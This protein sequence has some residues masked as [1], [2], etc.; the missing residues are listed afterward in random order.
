MTSIIKTSAFLNTLYQNEVENC[1]DDSEEID[2]DTFLNEQFVETLNLHCL[3]HSDFKL[4]L[5]D[6]QFYLKGFETLQLHNGFVE[7][8]IDEYFN[9]TLNFLLLIDF[10]MSL[11]K[12][13]IVTDVKSLSPEIILDLFIKLSHFYNFMS[14]IDVDAV[15]LKYLKY[16]L[17]LYLQSLNRTTIETHFGHVIWDL[18]QFFKYEV[19]KLVYKKHDT[20][21]SLAFKLKSVLETKY[22]IN[23]NGDLWTLKKYDSTQNYIDNTDYLHYFFK[24]DSWGNIDRKYEIENKPRDNY[25]DENEDDDDDYSSGYDSGYDFDGNY[26]TT[27]IIRVR[28][29][30]IES[31]DP[32]YDIYWNTFMNMVWQM[33]CNILEEFDKF[34]KHSD[35]TISNF[36]K[37]EQFY[38]PYF[39]KHKEYYKDKNIYKNK[40][41][42]Y[43]GTKLD[44]YNTFSLDEVKQL[45][46]IAY[47]MQHFD[48]IKQIVNTNK[49]FKMNIYFRLKKDIGYDEINKYLSNKFPKDCSKINE[50]VTTHIVLKNK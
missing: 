34:I 17:V 18:D 24:L 41:L 11:G 44:T 23:A 40:M 10:L 26:Y 48:I 47:D 39:D 12:T 20:N 38:S 16:M 22:N 35:I 30:N 49:S 15:F 8:D 6:I 33:T 1:Y 36:S 46:E 42:T 9:G 31:N 21:V 45:F 3:T 37:M 29:Y 43:V 25:D 2:Y 28:K 14:Y 19:V 13:G 50:N 27:N 32:N 5:E 4:T 7:P